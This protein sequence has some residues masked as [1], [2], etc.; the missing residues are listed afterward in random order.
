VS[1]LTLRVVYGLVLGATGLLLA[2]GTAAAYPQW[3]LSTG[4]SRCNQCHFSPGGG[5]AL[6][7]FGR[8]AIGEDLSTFEG[9]GAFLHGAARLPPALALGGDLRGAVLAHDAQDPGGGTVAAFPMQMELDGRLAVGGG[10][11]FFGNLGLRAKVRSQDAPVPTQNYQPTSTSRLV[12]REHFIVYQPASVGF[13]ARAGRFYAPF[14]LRLAEHVTYVRRDLG[15]NQL[16]ESYNVSAGYLQN[17]WEVH[18]TGFAPDFLRHIGNR[19]KGFAGY[20]E[21]RLLNEHAA[22]ALQTRLASGPGMTRLIAGGVG[23]IFVPRLRTLFLGELNLVRQ[24]FDSDLVGSR[25]QMVTAAG[26]AWLPARGVMVTVLGERNHEDLSVRG[27]AWNALD[28]FANLFPY[29]H[30]ELQL[31]LR[32]QRPA[33]GTSTRTAL[34]Q[35]HYSL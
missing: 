33:G 2:T 22:V 14:G 7:S 9:D 26:A 24:I 11:W 1:G 27:A 34:F 29:P 15:F 21:R 32:V 25:G 3:Q 17:G 5:G 18:L 13:Y 4:A 8:D 35:V 19:E 31:V 30:V 23:K 10:V 20:A 12:T 6:N 28:L 16:E